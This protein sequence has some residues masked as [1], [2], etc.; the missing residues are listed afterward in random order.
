TWQ[1][2]QG[3]Y[4]DGTTYTL[5]SPAVKLVQTDPNIPIPPNTQ[6]SL[7]V[8][9]AVFGTGLLEAVPESEIVQ[10]ADPEDRNGDGISGR[11]N[12][13]WHP[14]EKRN[15]LGRFGLKANTP[16]LT[17]QTAAAYINDMGVTN[18][19]FPGNDASPDIDRKILDNTIFYVQTLGVPARTLD[20][21]KQVHRGEKL[22]AQANCAGCHVATLHTGSAQSP[23]LAHQTIHPYSDLLLHDMGE[24]LADHRPDFQASGSEWRTAPLWGLG[25]VQTVLPYSGYLHD[26]RARTIEEAIVWHGGE[27]QASKTAYMAMAKGDREALLK[28]LN[29]L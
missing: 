3:Q 4:P 20:K 23:V 5:R 22:F 8:P 9:P 6:I 16:D 17:V 7:R 13:V 26:G 29:S 11:P 19:V 24:A 18:P 27:A 15:A 25:L 14:I 28:F 2:Q 12:Y 10:Q 21:D 1:E